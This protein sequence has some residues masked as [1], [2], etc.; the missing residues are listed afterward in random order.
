MDRQSLTAKQ[1]RALAKELRARIK[2]QKKCGCPAD[3]S[4]WNDQ[5]GV[6][7]TLDEATLFAELLRPLQAVP[8]AAEVDAALFAELLGPLQAVPNRR[9]RGTGVVMSDDDYPE[10]V[11][12]METYKLRDSNNSGTLSVIVDDDGDAHITVWNDR[13]MNSLEFCTLMGGGRSARTRMAII[14][15]ADSIRRDNEDAAGLTN[16]GSQ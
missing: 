10:H 7:I 2:D 3:V 14:R 12:P 1:K 13:G 5:Y 4:S 9:T 15:L 11:V 16:G 8:S 6:V